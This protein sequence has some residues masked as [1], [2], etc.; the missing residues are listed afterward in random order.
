MGYDEGSEMFKDAYAWA[1]IP[2]YQAIWFIDRQALETERMFE[3]SL[4]EIELDTLTILQAYRWEVGP[5]LSNFNVVER[6]SHEIIISPEHD[7]TS[8][9]INQCPNYIAD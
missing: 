7:L 5:V 4:T 8:L 3:W 9:Q 2:V 1:V 6:N